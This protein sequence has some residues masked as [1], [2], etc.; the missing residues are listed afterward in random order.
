MRISFL[1]ALV[2]LSLCL[3]SC[4]S[5]SEPDP[6]CTSTDLEL[7]LESKVDPT[8]S[9]LGNIKVSTSGASGDLTYRINGSGS[10]ASGDFPNIS[11]GTYE[12]SVQDAQKCEATLAVQLNVPD[13]GIV[14][15][16]TSTTAGCGTS[17]GQINL[18]TSG[19]A[20]GYK[21]QL[22]NNAEQTSGEFENL[23]SGTYRIKV[24]DADGCFTTVDANV[25]NGVELISTI[26]PIIS[27]NCAVSGCHNGFQSPNLS[28]EAGILASANR[29]KSRTSAG[30]M[31]PSGEPDLS[32]QQIA[33]I[34]CWADDLAID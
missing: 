19:G 13:G 10:Q 11:A 1:T 7:L 8:C 31:P 4:L 29:I 33:D 12:I 34:A 28:S 5:E 20:G 27:A 32:A 14:A 18:Q 23:V 9:A 22:G 26:A 24:T 17:N 6:R 30:T 21:F 2:L 15:T 3:V 16:A 25:A